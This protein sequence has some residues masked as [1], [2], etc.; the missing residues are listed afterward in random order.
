MV[1]EPG[2]EN[3][4]L[5]VALKCAQAAADATKGKDAA[6]LD[7]LAAVHA[8]RGDHAKAVETQTKA[9]A[10]SEDDD[11]KKELQATLEKYQA[12]AKK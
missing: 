2:F 4:D 7:T 10:A 9:L 1:G 11:Q 8:K 3:P 6:V 12:A 5:D